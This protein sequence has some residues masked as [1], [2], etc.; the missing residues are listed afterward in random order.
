MLKMRFP[1]L[2]EEDFSFE[3]GER[4]RMLSKLEAKLKMTRPELEWL[5]ADLQL[6]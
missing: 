5:F 6:H 2:S 3:E 1:I 4:E